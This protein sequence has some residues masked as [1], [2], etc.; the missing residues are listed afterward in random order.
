MVLP[1]FHLALRVCKGSFTRQTMIRASRAPV[2]PGR[3]MMPPPPPQQQGAAAACDESAPAAAPCNVKSLVFLARGAPLVVVLPLDRRVDR[4]Q[5]ATALG[6][7]PGD[8]RLA[9][10]DRLP[11]L[12]GFPAGSV[13][14]VG[15]QPRLPVVVDASLAQ[16]AFCS[17]GNGG[18]VGSGSGSGC[19]SSSAVLCL[20]VADLLQATGATVAAVAVDAEGDV[21]GRADDEGGGSCSM[22]QLQ[23]QQQQQAAL[24][25]T[26][27]AA[28]EDVT[29]AASDAEAQRRQVIDAALAALPL[30]WEPG[31]QLVE[32]EGLVVQVRRGC[33]GKTVLYCPSAAGLLLRVS[34][35]APISRGADTAHC[36]PAA[37]RQPHPPATARLCAACA[38]LLDAAPPPVALS[39]G[40]PCPRL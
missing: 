5:L 33:V 22:E 39:R 1:G 23:Q 17:S 8:V 26:A 18:G 24:E 35:E 6:I 16:E 11:S 21:S 14:P 19:G 32:L 10:P 28:P 34:N 37:L 27:A 40:R 15:H 30:P 31:S 7:R 25:G 38:R 36:P 20:P 9:P 13:P 2:A 3:S 4:R 29:E 12:C